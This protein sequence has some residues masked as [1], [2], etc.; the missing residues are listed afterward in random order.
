[1]GAVFARFLAFFP[2]FQQISLCGTGLDFMGHAHRRGTVRTPLF[3]P[4]AY[5]DVHTGLAV[6]ADCVLR[7]MFIDFHKHRLACGWSL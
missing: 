5:L 6:D 2:R 7:G 4:F 1:M 3:R